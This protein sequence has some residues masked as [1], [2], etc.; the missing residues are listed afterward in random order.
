M[1]KALI[2]YGGWEGHAPRETADLFANW[3]REDRFEV[4]LENSLSPLDDAASLQA[5]DLIIPIWTMGKITADQCRHVCQAVEQG[6]GLA[7]CHGGMCDAFRE[8]PDWQFMT[9]GNWVSHPG[10]NGTRYTVHIRNSSS[11]IVEEVQ[12]FEVNSEQYYL[13]VDP[14]VEVLASTRFP[15]AAGPH[16]PNGSFDMP[17][18]WTKRWGLGRVYYNALGHQT[19]I[20]DIPE[21][22]TLMRRGMLWA[23]R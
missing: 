5:M 8:S 10:N 4:H 7:G 21:A 1:K 15:V 6:T 2:L 14:A 20:W 19:D 18:V 13:H 12:D 23:A 9:G 16:S 22:A 3:L 17:Q 11:P